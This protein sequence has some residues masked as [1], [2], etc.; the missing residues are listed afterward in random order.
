MLGN[1]GKLHLGRL[2]IG[3]MIVASVACSSPGGGNPCRK[4][5][6]PVL[7]KS[8][9]PKVLDSFWQTHEAGQVVLQVWVE[10][11]GTVTFQRIV[12]TSGQDYSSS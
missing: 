6:A 7:V 12:R 1:I 11:D 2:A 3:A 8:P 4:P 10:T 5:T 9:G